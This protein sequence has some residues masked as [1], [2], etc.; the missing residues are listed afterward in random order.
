MRITSPLEKL[1]NSTINVIVI[2]IIFLPFL[3]FLNISLFS[4]KFVFIVLFFIYKLAIIFFNENRSIGMI[5]TN[6]YWKKTYPLKNQLLHAVLYTLSFS[7]LLFSIFFPFDIFLINILLIQLP[8]IIITGTTFHGYIAGKM[9]TVKKP[10][11]YISQ[12]AT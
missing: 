12:P 4:K 10:N 1:L 2:F 6:T 8:S 5:I 9:M 3:I 7:T 11:P